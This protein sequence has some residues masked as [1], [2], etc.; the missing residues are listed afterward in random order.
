MKPDPSLA[1]ESMV[2]NFA[3]LL[4]DDIHTFPKSTEGENEKVGTSGR[5]VKV[6]CVV[7]VISGVGD[8]YFKAG[9]LMFSF[10]I[11]PR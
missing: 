7:L 9:E 2:E 8:A 1:D 11:I 3:P 4:F 6:H 5:L 10:C